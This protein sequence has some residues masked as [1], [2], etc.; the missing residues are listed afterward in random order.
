M[1]E[2]EPTKA[3]IFD[4]G[5]VLVSVEN[6]RVVPFFQQYTQEAVL[7]EKEIEQILFGF[8]AG[9]PGARIQE[10]EYYRQFTLGNITPEEFFQNVQSLLCFPQEK[11]TLEVFKRVWPDRFSLIKGSVKLLK[12]LRHHKRY[13]LSDT[14]ELDAE[15]I[16]AQFPKLFKEFDATYLS[17]KYGTDKYGEEGWKWIICHS[18]CDPS[19]IVFIDDRDTH[20]DR[21]KEL[22][23]HGIVFKNPGQ[24]RKALQELKFL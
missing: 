20:V 10:K 9:T 11:I 3:V 1:K 14:N 8:A 22:G 17:Y 2:N 6:K 21:A 15:Q 13:L 16:M 18:G 7:D 4:L 19:S 5:N 23:M 24:T 12:D